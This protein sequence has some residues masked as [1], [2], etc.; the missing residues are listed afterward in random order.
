MTFYDASFAHAHRVQAGLP[1]VLR[2]ASAVRC[3]TT[4]T[5]HSLKKALTACIGGGRPI[6]AASGVALS[7]VDTRPLL[8][9]TAA[10]GVGQA[11]GRGGSGSGRGIAW[12]V[13]VPRQVDCRRTRGTG[14]A[15]QKQQLCQ[16]V[17]DRQER[18][19]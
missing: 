10:P 7:A 13:E 18:P 9:E 17:D 11:E 8:P 6:Y 14:G 4:G 15:Q 2:S 16:N 12:G 3:C 1:A 5:T 19:V